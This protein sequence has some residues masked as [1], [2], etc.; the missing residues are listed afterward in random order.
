VTT[1]SGISDIEVG[2]RPD[3]LSVIEGIL[4]GVD[5]GGTVGAHNKSPLILCVQKNSRHCAIAP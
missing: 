1:N 3:S 5:A 2:E 4:I